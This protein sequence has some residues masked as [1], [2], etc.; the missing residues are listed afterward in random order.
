MA[1]DNT[2]TNPVTE[3]AASE[4]PA[5][6]LTPDELDDLS[7]AEPEPA[8]LSYTGQ[9]F[10]VSGLVRRMQSEDILIPIFGTVDPRVATAGFQRSF[11]WRKPQMDRFIESIL[12]GYPIPGIFLVRQGDRRY[13]VLDGH[14][15]LRSLEHFVE[16]IHE[17]KQF[18]LR[19]VADRLVGMTYKGLPE[20]LR[21]LFDDT[22]I[23]ATIVATDGSSES[24]EAV[25][26]IFE[27]LNSGGTQLTPHE[28]RVAL[29]AGPV[30]VFLESLN[31]EPAWR[32]L[33]GPRSPRLRDQEL[34]LRIIALFA[35]SETYS[36]PLKTFLN[37]YCGDNRE[38]SYAEQDRIRGMF[39]RA[40]ELVL[41][42]AGRRI[43]RPGGSQINAAFTDAVFVGLMRR[44]E[45]GP[46]IEAEEAGETLHQLAGN[47]EMVE[48]TTRATADEEIVKKRL[49]ISTQAFRLS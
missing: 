17:G 35:A 9:D 42:G 6:Y 19:N 5:S 39:V 43:L 36:R 31:S 27:R 41:V 48:A 44:L 45:V 22:F 14:Q 7:E 12:L 21:R 40:S 30:I 13:L 29:Y 46:P 26:Q 3:T 8:L 20:D 18:A 37:K 47:A 49:A 15:R 10:D 34:V 24:L 16:G 1:D 4:D 38:I 23:P 25:Y 32:T 33:Y 28:V 11:V 2:A